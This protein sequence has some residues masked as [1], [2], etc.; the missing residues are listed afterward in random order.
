MKISIPTEAV[1]ENLNADLEFR[2]A[3]RLWDFDLL[4]RIGDERY[5]C[6]IVEGEVRRFD[7]GADSFERH[8]AVLGGTDED[9]SKMLAPI[10]P[11]YHQD[12][13]GA[14]F[15]HGFEMS[16]DLESVFAYYGALNRMLE[17][18]RSTVNAEMS[19]N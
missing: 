5:I 9:W 19:H 13:F 10:P 17:V 12:F 16:C 3:A 2:Q 1:R 4:I 8:S 7:A 18:M 11:P 6:E 15:Q 14:F